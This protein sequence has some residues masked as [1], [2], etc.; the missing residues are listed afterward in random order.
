MWWL[1]ACAAE[2]PLDIELGDVWEV[3]LADAH[4][5]TV[6]YSADGP[7]VAVSSRGFRR[8]PG[9]WLGIVGTD[10]VLD[11][12]P[13]A[14]ATKPDIAVFVDGSAQ[15]GFQRTDG[16]WLALEV[17]PAPPLHRLAEPAE[18]R[19]N[20]SLDLAVAGEGLRAV[21]YDAEDGEARIRARSL[22]DLE[23]DGGLPAVIATFD[24]TIRSAPDVAGHPDG[25]TSVAFT[26]QWHDA[27]DVLIVET[28]DAH[29][30]RR[31]R[32]RRP[33]SSPGLMPRRPT[34]DVGFD[35][36]QLVVFRELDAEARSHGVW[37]AALDGAGRALGEPV[38]V[39]DGT[40][41]RP[42]AA[43]LG[44]EAVLLVVEAAGGI[45][46]GT[47]TF[48]GL[49]PLAPLRPISRGVDPERPHVAVRPVR[50]GHEAL[51]SWETADGRVVVRTLT[52]R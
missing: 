7:L 49:A 26:E 38:R 9:A 19:V 14:E 4:H 33:P 6:A 35:G 13:T 45:A 50:G 17:G 47:W 23:P 8:A 20:A 51:V 37:L 39:L 41:D 5:A 12:S 46:A 15:L 28:F 18:A 21:W 48:P 43:R 44:D 29:G 11:L 10:Q 30:A 1:L 22:T 36:H 2:G 32:W 16:L 25:A 24:D 31:G 42:V 40:A 34:L 27:A 52:V 3:P